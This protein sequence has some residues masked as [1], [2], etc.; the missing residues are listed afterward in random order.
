MGDPVRNRSV[1]RPK[2]SFEMGDQGSEKTRERKGGR[3]CR[4]DYTA[5]HDA[6][7]N[8]GSSQRILWSASAAQQGT[9]YCAYIRP[10]PAAVYNR[11]RALGGIAICSP[12]P[13]TR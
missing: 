1:S 6:L 7:T 2:E 12:V 4:P 5:G 10:N 9:L 13:R 8:Y 11:V 3:I